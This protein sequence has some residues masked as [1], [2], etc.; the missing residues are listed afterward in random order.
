MSWNEEQFRLIEL[1]IKRRAMSNLEFRELALTNPEA[2]IAELIDDPLPVGWKINIVESGGANLTVVLPDP[3]PG[4][5]ELS[6]AELEQ[7]AGGRNNNNN[8]VKP[9]STS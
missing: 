9:P 8:N 6:D 2:A 7:V 3:V 4:I 5:D 1:E